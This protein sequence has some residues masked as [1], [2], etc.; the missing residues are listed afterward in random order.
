MSGRILKCSCFE[1]LHLYTC[2]T[3]VCIMYVCTRNS[4]QFRDGNVLFYQGCC[5][6]RFFTVA[7]IMPEI[8]IG[9]SISLEE[10]CAR[11]DDDFRKDRR[12][13]FKLTGACNGIHVLICFSRVHLHITLR[14]L[15][16]EGLIRLVIHMCP[17]NPITVLVGVRVHGF[18]SS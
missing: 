1:H 15:E 2:I 5:L 16:L 9:F 7:D 14:K 12:N 8:D 18:R 13:I 6:N 17:T 3:N 11:E 10:I 4:T